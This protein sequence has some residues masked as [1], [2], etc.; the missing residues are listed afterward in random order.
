MTMEAVPTDTAKSAAICGNSVSAA[1][2]SDWLAKL[3]TASAAIA[4]LAEP[5]IGEGCGAGE[6]DG[7][8]SIGGGGLSTAPPDSGQIGVFHRDDRQNLPADRG[9]R[10]HLC[11]LGGVARVPRRPS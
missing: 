8:D 1:L 5:G 2:T 3:A 4:A 6:G 7:V 9:R 11:R 10:P